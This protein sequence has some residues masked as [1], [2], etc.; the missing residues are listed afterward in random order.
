MEQG[1]IEEARDLCRSRLQNDR[2]NTDLLRLMRLLEPPQVRPSSATG[3][4]HRP[5]A[6][7]IAQHHTRY[8]GQWV[9]LSHGELVAADPSLVVALQRARTTGRHD[10]LAHH[11]SSEDA[12]P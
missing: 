6:D 2:S 7:W 5:D 10:L 4:D 1:R 3:V 8:Q 12:K 9:V 11:I